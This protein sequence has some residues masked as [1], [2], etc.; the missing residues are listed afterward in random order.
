MDPSTL[1]IVSPSSLENL[2]SIVD[3][4]REFLLEQ[5]G[6]TDVS[7]SALLLISEAVANGMEHGN[8]N[9]P[10]KTVEIRLVVLADKVSVE[11][12]DEGTGFDRES[13][14]DPLLDENL[15]ATGGRGL[16][17]IESLATNVEYLNG[18]QCVRFELER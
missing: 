7:H 16:F 13:V 15:L 4:S 18:G 5:L 14:V 1:K 12:E 9:D 11:V 10:T 17:L 6:E 8:N 2:D 3:Q